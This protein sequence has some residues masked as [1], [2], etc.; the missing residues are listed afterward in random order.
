MV[1]DIKIVG[2]DQ[3]VSSEAYRGHID[4]VHVCYAFLR[5]EYAFQETKEQAVKK[6][7]VWG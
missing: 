2:S 1:L 7:S 3:S 4:A 6:P 5:S